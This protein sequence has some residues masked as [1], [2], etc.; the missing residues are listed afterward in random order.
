MNLDKHCFFKI[1]NYSYRT[2]TNNIYC[3]WCW[4]WCSFNTAGSLS[5]N[6]SKVG[7]HIMFSRYSTMFVQ[8]YLYYNI[9]NRSTLRFAVVQKRCSLYISK[10]IPR[11]L[12]HLKIRCK[13]VWKI[14][15]LVDLNSCTRKSNTWIPWTETLCCTFV[16]L[17]Y[18]HTFYKN[19]EVD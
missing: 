15:G 13:A 14:N 16:L 9:L 7:K 18:R 8:L 10:D 5:C 4:F 11:I 12:P 3:N 19:K 6:I 2:W 17:Q 1:V